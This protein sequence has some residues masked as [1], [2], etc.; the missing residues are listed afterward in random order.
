MQEESSKEIVERT[1]N[2]VKKLSGLIANLLDVSKIQAGKLILDPTLFDLNVLIQAISS[3]HQ[4][5]TKTHKITFDKNTK[6]KR[7]N[8][9]RRRI[10]QVLAN[11]IGKAI[12][13]TPDSGNKKRRKYFR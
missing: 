11:I 1:V 7:V 2:Q 8:P 5:T 13:Y 10:E 9:A 4:Q 6:R 3:T 12:K